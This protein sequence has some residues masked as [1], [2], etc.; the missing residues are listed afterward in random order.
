M[1][2]VHYFFLVLI[3]CLGVI[4]SILARKLTVTAALTGGAI[5]FLLFYGAGFTG[6]FLMAAFFILGTAAT[7]WKRRTKE[8]LAIAE[9][10]KGRRKASQVLANAGLAG[11]AALFIRLFP[12]HALL[13]QLIIA[14]CFSSA[15]ADTLSSEL[16]SVYGKRFYNILSFKKD[17]RGLDGV[18]SWEGTVLGLAGSA[19]IAILFAIGFG[20]DVRFL[21]I[22][23]AGT[24]GNLSDS[25]L[26]AT[27]E[28]RNILHNDAVNFLNTGVAA[29]VVVVLYW[30]A[31]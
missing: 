29:L 5:G 9:E 2:Q 22:L 6:L 21:W 27:L 30:L 20:W 16:G 26:G 18:V 7:S 31:Q 23:L 25:V 14:A 4:G 28:R 3:L 12:Q 8:K 19:I 24:L 1:V 15:T 13:L 17:R 10:N 11:C